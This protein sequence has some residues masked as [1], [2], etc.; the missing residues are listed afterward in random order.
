MNT[1]VIAAQNPT[2]ALVEQLTS[3]KV[4]ALGDAHWYGDL[5][6]NLSSLALSDAVLAV[7]QTI[8]LEMGASIHQQWLN[9]YLYGEVAEDRARLQSVLLDSLVFPV[10]FAPYH[11]KFFQRVRRINQARLAAGQTPVQLVLAEPEIDWHMIRSSQDYKQYFKQR[12]T[13]LLK[14]IGSLAEKQQPCI[15]LC[16][17]WHIL[18]QSRAGMPQ[19]FGSMMQ[20]KYP[21]IL[22]SVWPHMQM[23]QHSS[24]LHVQAP[25]LIDCHQ[26]AFGER[27]VSD[28]APMMRKA[29]NLLKMPPVRQVV[30]AYLYYGPQSRC[31]DFDFSVWQG[32]DHQEI[33][34]RA[35]FLNER[36]RDLVAKV[37]LCLNC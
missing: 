3:G 18:K 30:D 29:V 2:N 21:D 16:G 36:Q 22:Y 27:P 35:S 19:T 33:T 10:W 8:V 5:F 6:E 20:K 17:A 37:L 34:R 14:V 9:D 31:S 32:L 13:Q 23:E 15:L 1:C 12:D 26:T 25:A 7:C 11:L 28:I 4:V 24:L